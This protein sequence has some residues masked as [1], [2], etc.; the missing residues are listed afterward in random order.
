MS[1]PRIRLTI[2]IVLVL[3]TAVSFSFWAATRTASPETQAAQR[4]LSKCMTNQKKL[5]ASMALYVADNGDT[6]PAKGITWLDQVAPYVTDKT[7]LHCPACDEGGYALNEKLLGLKMSSLVKPN[8][9]PLIFDSS[10]VEKNSVSGFSSLPTPGRHRK[11]NAIGF[12]GGHVEFLPD[13][14]TPP[15]DQPKTKG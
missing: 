3:V 1:Q 2:G 11:G 6:F 12:V 7:A 9:V 13:G 10:T 8:D 15:N 14:R 5:I 4:V